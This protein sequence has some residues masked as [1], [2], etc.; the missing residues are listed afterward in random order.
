MYSVAIRSILSSKPPSLGSLQVELARRPAESATDAAD[1]AIDFGTA[2][3]LALMVVMR[4]ADCHAL[5]TIRGGSTGEVVREQ[6]N[7]IR[8]TPIAE[9][10]LAP[11]DKDNLFSRLLPRGS[12]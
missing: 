6:K 5:C 11:I 3:V 4:L 9:R 1:A 10:W 2:N 12:Q 8:A 7:R